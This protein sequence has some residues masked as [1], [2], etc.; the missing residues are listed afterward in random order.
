MKIWKEKYEASRRKVKIYFLEIIVAISLFIMAFVMMS[1]L[2]IKGCGLAAASILII[3]SGFLS[4]A[5]HISPSILEF[6]A[7]LYASVIGIKP[8]LELKVIS[9]LALIFLF[10]IIGTEIDYYVLKNHTNKIHIPLLVFFPSFIGT[11]ILL[12]L[13]FHLNSIGA[14]FIAL[15]LSTSSTDAIKTVLV[16][17][18]Y[19]VIYV[20]EIVYFSAMVI[21]IIAI[22]ILS[23]IL[24]GYNIVGLL[25]PI[26]IILMLVIAPRTIARLQR[27]YHIFEFEI[28]L[29][30][31]LLI[32]L[33]VILEAIGL[34]APLLA[35]IFGLTLSESIRKHEL[36]ERRLKGMALGL[37]TPILFFT[38]GL[39]TNIS[40]LFR[41]KIIKIILLTAFISLLIQFL[42]AYIPLKVYLQKLNLRRFP[43][44]YAFKITHAIPILYIVHTMSIIDNML[45]NI[46][47]ICI[48]I[49]ILAFIIP[50][51]ML[52]HPIIVEEIKV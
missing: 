10:F 21:D 5:F 37:F 9:H 39:L 11:F 30:A 35:F 25:Y 23:L 48:L 36:L 47:V 52:P 24:T 2:K 41:M 20:G 6:L 1:Y 28:K 42:T 26:L 43:L 15:A 17:R 4:I 13:V 3:A 12:H 8:F 51:K 38:S 33:Y 29:L 14:L 27:K 45:Y 19:D 18:G 32:S 22:L 7:G 31:F 46:G 16:E 44:I 50:H 40:L 34:H 49:H